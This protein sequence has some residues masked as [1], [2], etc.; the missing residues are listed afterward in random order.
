MRFLPFLGLIGIA[1]LVGYPSL[2]HDRP[3]PM[4]AHAL[5]DADA[6]ANAREPSAPGVDDWD[7]RDT[8]PARI[9]KAA[10]FAY[11]K[12]HPPTPLPAVAFAALTGPAAADA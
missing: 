2:R 5:P 12:N 9:A 6:I 11:S 4:P 7:V 3:A 8:K 1:A 10:A